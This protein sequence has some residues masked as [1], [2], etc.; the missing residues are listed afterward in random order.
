MNSFCRKYERPIFIPETKL[1]VPV[2]EE[3]MLQRCPPLTDPALW[4]AAFLV[5][6]SG[7]DLILFLC[8]SG[9]FL[10]DFERGS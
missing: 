1:R 8:S 5:T 6:R 2:R 9:N 3:L 7:A 4:K 10:W